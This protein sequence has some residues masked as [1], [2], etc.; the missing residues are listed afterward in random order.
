[1]F[2]PKSAVSS[3]DLHGLL[4]VL[5][6]VE[7]DVPNRERLAQLEG[8]E[9]V[10]AAVGA[11]QIRAT[12]AFVEE[13]RRA[14]S[15]WRQRAREAADAGDF[16]AYCLARDRAR[17]SSWDEELGRADGAG[18]SAS[19]SESQP[20]SQLREE[21]TGRPGHRLGRRPKEG[22][23]ISAQVALARRLSPSRGSQDVG[24]AVTL[25]RDMPQTLA[26][27]E[28]G[29]LSEWR[30]QIVVREVR[31]LSP[32]QRA[33]VDEELAQVIGDELVQL[34]DKE[35]ADRVRAIA[36][37]LEPRSVVD[38]ASAAAADR[39]VT[40]RPAP[41]TMSYV[42]ALLPVAQGVAVHAALTA[43]AGSARAAGDERNAGQVMADTLVTRV[44]G[45]E[46]APTVPVEVQLVM[47]D[48]VL[49]AGDDTPARVPGY[50]IVPAG[51]ARDLVAN[52]KAEVWVRRL[53]THPAD[54]TLVAMD[55]TR[56][57]FEGGLRRF[58]VARDGTCRTPWCDAPVRQ[59]DHV[60]DHAE[61]G[62]TSA[63]NAQGDCVRCNHLK[64]LPGFRARVLADPSSGSPLWRTHTV[65]LFT[66]HGLTYRSK[67]PPV[68]P[69]VDVFFSRLESALEIDLDAA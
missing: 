59:I 24:N 35:L 8:L 57:C 39:R 47:T 17:L 43:A 21:R 6:R 14:A 34:G 31:V 37:R 36:Y 38:K 33:D 19:S 9:R 4:E 45:Q 56:R 68:L 42:T 23:G 11:A 65:E 49:L 60:V 16:D 1:M 41:D 27:L 10:R 50:G 40:I 69:V 25:V 30:A 64:Q 18:S 46:H 7:S 48:R 12:A 61:G 54:G 58:V 5:T 55:S 29:D 3:S 20:S 53:Y 44:T 15:E 22:I 51:L 63:A 52:S 62:L 28:S 26:R 67:A 32:D 66:P 13:E 2:E